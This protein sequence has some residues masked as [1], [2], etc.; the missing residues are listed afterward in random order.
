MLHVSHMDIVATVFLTVLGHSR[1]CFCTSS[2]NS[3]CS[4]MITHSFILR[5]ICDKWQYVIYVSMFMERYRV[6]SL[7]GKGHAIGKITWVFI[8]NREITEVES[9]PTAFLYL[10]MLLP[11]GF[12]SPLF[13]EENEPK[14]GYYLIYFTVYSKVDILSWQL[15][16]SF[17]ICK[18]LLVRGLN[19]IACLY[20]I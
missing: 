5:G 2:W 20:L 11:K 13:I 6:A 9:L 10:I 8:L 19:R 12:C 3:Y 4:I 14:R 16:S 17:T 1:N 18:Y 15:I 7:L